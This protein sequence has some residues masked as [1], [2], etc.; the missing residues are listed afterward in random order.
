LNDASVIGPS[1]KASISQEDRMTKLRYGHAA[2]HVRDTFDEAV[3]AFIH[4]KPGTPEPLVDFEVNY[5]AQAIPISQVCRML[6]NSTDILPGGLFD[7][8]SDLDMKR[9]TYGACARAMLRSIRAATS[10]AA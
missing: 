7:R 9:R 2:G 8:L 10:K 6:W 3:E 1:F 4:W 5:E